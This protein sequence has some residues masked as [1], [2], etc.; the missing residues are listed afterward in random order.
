M[1]SGDSHDR[2]SKK[3]GHYKMIRYGTGG[4]RDVIG[5]DFIETSI[6]KVVVGVAL[7]AKAEKNTD[8]PVIVGFDR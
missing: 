2:K 8:W 6:R 5:K 7:L 4:W 3:G 1:N